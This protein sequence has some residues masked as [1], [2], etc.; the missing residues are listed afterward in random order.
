MSTLKIIF[1]AFAMLY[2]SSLFGAKQQTVNAILGDISYIQKFGHAPC[3]N[4]NEQIR[5]Q[6]HLEF[7]ESI[8][9]LRDVSNMPKALQE[10][11]IQKPLHIVLPGLNPQHLDGGSGEF[12]IQLR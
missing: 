6:T 4:T 7:V 10:K 11:M 5:I 12:H 3:E 1:V 9:R 2:V 8:L